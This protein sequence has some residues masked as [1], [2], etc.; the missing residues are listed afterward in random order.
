MDYFLKVIGENWDEAVSDYKIELVQAADEDKEFTDE[1]NA[2]NFVKV[3]GKPIPVM[4]FSRMVSGRRGS[5]AREALEE[6]GLETYLKERVIGPGDRCGF[7]G[8]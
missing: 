6:K 2:T 7:D 3:W 4:R 8:A 1:E 5:N